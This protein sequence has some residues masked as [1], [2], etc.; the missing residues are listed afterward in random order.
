MSGWVD[1]FKTD[2]VEPH[3]AGEKCVNHLEP[4]ETKLMEYATY[5]N[6][7]TIKNENSDQVKTVLKWKQWLKILI[8]MT[9]NN[10]HNKIGY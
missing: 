8:V 5:V 7:T 1:S 6:T 9:W 10:G 4:F 3:G 2:E